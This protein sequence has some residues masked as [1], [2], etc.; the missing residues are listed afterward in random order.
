MSRVWNTPVFIFATLYFAV[1]GLFSY[2]T[3]P[4]TAWIAKQK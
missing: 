1:A 4:I 3:R 2:V